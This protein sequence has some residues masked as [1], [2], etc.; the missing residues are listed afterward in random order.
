MFYTVYTSVDGVYYN[1][2][3][4]DKILTNELDLSFNLSNDRYIKISVHFSRHTLLNNGLYNYIWDVNH[5]FIAMK[6]YKSE[7][8]FQSN[9]IDINTAGE[10]IAIDTCDNYE[11]KKCKY[12]LYDL[13]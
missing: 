2:L 6:K 1:P 12:K 7:T 9:D 4:S 11:N 8:V 5:I 13:Y 3:N 10:Y